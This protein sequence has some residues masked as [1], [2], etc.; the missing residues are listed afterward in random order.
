LRTILDTIEFECP[1]C[2]FR[3]KADDLRVVERELKKR[4]EQVV[5]EKTIESIIEEKKRR[6]TE[7]EN[8]LKSAA[9][10]FLFGYIGS[11]IIKMIKD[12]KV[13]RAN[14]LSG[15]YQQIIN[16]LVGILFV[17]VYFCV[18]YLFSRLSRRK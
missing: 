9:E 8:P 1:N 14:A 7:K 2:F 18:R 16:I 11:N 17:T 10:V 13:D 6:K 12:P 3:I 4:G 5:S 15:M